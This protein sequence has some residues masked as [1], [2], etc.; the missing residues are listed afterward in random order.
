[1]QP[2]HVSST[3]LRYQQAIALRSFQLLADEPE[4]L[5]GHDTGPTPMEL[6]LAALG[7]CKAITLQMY[8]E[9]KGWP[10]SKVAVDLVPQTLNGQT[11]IVAQ[12]HLEGTLTDDQRQRLLIIANKCPVHKLLAGE[13]AIQTTLAETNRPG[14]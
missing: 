5:G 7:A 3:D 12:L 8:A 13:T 9:R 14:D 2:I 11:E 1:M 6:L 4:T 10:L